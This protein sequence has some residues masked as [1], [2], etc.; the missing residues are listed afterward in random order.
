M[1]HHQGEIFMV[2]ELPAVTGIP[3]LFV[4]FISSKFAVMVYIS[5][6]WT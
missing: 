3:L 1:G 4:H 6:F 2:M 5:S